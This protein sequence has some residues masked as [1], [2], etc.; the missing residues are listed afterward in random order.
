[1]SDCFKIALYDGLLASRLALSLDRWR[2]L[3]DIVAPVL[4]KILLYTLTIF[5]LPS[6]LC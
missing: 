5:K 4:V 2:R 3:T 1:M 6:L